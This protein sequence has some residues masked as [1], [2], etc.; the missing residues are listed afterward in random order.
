MGMTTAVEVLNAGFRANSSTL[1][2]DITLRVKPGTMLGIIG[3]N[4]AGKTTLLGLMAGDL[5]PT[6]GEVSL[7]DRPIGEY[8]PADLARQ[9]AV[10][11]QQN[12]V[13]FPFTTRDIVLMGRH[14]YH[15]D[16]DNS[17]EN[18]DRVAATAMEATDTLSLAHRIY[19]SLSAGEQ[20]RVALARIFAQQTPVILLDEP[21]ATLDIHHQEHTMGLLRRQAAAG[22]AVISVLH[23]LNLG[24][25]YAD[26]L[27]LLSE[28]AVVATGRPAQVLDERLLSETY[29][30]R[31]RVMDHPHR[32]CPLVVVE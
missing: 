30:Q 31:M 25:A 22:T 11:P 10:L 24:A 26:R 16:A 27:V 2:H 7:Q 23:D 20:T 28:G 5:V 17:R 18:D 19:P 6:A 3:P 1:L 29:R 32:N 9:R 12:L 13:P 8:R 4:G 21:T 15:G 14:P